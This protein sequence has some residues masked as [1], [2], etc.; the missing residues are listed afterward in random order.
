MELLSVK[1]PQ[2]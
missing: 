1:Q 2:V